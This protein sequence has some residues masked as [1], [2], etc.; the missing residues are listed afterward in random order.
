MSS[1]RRRSAWAGTVA[2]PIAA[3][4]LVA[5][6]ALA[7]TIAPDDTTLITVTSASTDPSTASTHWV[8]QAYD[9]N[10]PDVNAPFLTPD[11][12]FQTGP[13][14]PPLGT[15]SHVMRTAQFSGDTELFRTAKYDGTYATDIQHISYST[16]TQARSGDAVKQPAYLRLSFDTDGD[17]APDVS[18][19][20]EP[21]INHPDEVNAGNGTW[22]SWVTTD[23][24]EMW[25]IGGGQQP[26]DLTTLQDWAQANP[27][28]RI[29]N[30]ASGSAGGVSFI[31]GCAGQNQVNGQFAV[32]GFGI[33]ATADHANAPAASHELNDFEGPFQGVNT[34][35]FRVTTAN[36]HGWT[37]VAYNTTTFDTTTPRQS[38]VFGPGNPPAGIG[39]HKFRADSTTDNQPPDQD[40]LELYRSTSL[41]GVKLGDVRNLDY[42]TYDQPA[43]GVTG[44]QPPYLR[45]SVDSDGD[46]EGDASLFYEPSINHPSAVADNTWQHWMTGDELWSI[47]GGESPSDLTTLAG[48]ASH[49]PKAV[50]R[51]A[52]DAIGSGALVIAVG[53][54][55]ANQDQANFY[56]DNVHERFFNGVGPETDQTFDFEPIVPA[57]SINVPSVVTGRTNIAITGNT[58]TNTAHP[59]ALF[60]KTL[61][62]S[63]YAKVAETNAAPD[64]TYAFHRTV[65]KESSFIVRSYNRTNSVAKTV[66]V[67]VAL[68]LALTSPQ[69]GK[70]FMSV[71]TSPH[72]V[73]ETVK[74]YRVNANGTHSLLA[75]RTTGSHGGAHAT[76][77]YPSGHR[78]TAY[79]TVTPPA[80]N[81]KGH[82]AYKSI[83]VS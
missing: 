66:K 72:A 41:D 74:F 64:G 37:P 8:E 9:C 4:M 51:N 67:R 7:G 53:A 11:Q 54:S 18:L 73:G 36:P 42:W 79:A 83:R 45:L 26:A 35:S 43:R 48:Y 55:G 52:S 70:L 20:Y 3:A 76:I 61:G 10:D 5:T 77:S 2:G 24:G 63:S 49:H 81:L 75:T 71:R 29:E 25:S 57:P 28:A 16:F 34:S 46:G 65:T 12:G 22:Q 14:V 30:T 17:N 56:V 78:V 33:E 44:Q 40:V 38:D 31:A 6:P 68:D 58:H 27:D 19:Y 39:S 47:G 80:G 59:V 69:K 32:D 23:P 62:Q 21:S 15:G 13:G 1:A 60:E 82:S 50:V